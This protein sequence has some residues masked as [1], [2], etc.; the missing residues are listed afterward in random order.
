MRE[1]GGGGKGRGRK[2]EED[3]QMREEAGGKEAGRRKGEGA[4]GRGFKTGTGTKDKQTREEGG[5][6]RRGSVVEGW[7]KL[8]RGAARGL[9]AALSELLAD[10]VLEGTLLA[11]DV[12]DH[13]LLVSG[14]RRPQ[15]LYLL[16][17]SQS[18]SPLFSAPH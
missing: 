16:Q 13:G 8:M 17:M 7:Q 12:P 1:E 14:A 4:K 2:R 15:P 9:Q 6:R 5:G 11:E 3:K 10:H 18:S